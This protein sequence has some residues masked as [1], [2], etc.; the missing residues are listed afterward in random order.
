[1][2]W[3]HKV[4]VL[5]IAIS[6]SQTLYEYHYELVRGYLWQTIPHEVLNRDRLLLGAG[7]YL[8][9]FT[10]TGVLTLFSCLLQMTMWCSTPHWT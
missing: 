9:S 4:F 1:M 7:T 8:I 10:L 6:R 2:L 5:V 3:Y